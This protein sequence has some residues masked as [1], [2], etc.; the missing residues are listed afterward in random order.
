MSLTCL[1]KP[2]FLDLNYSDLLQNA[3]KNTIKVT[4]DEAKLVE[5]KTRSRL[6]FRMRSGRITLDLRL[7]VS[8]LPHHHS[9]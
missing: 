6:W 8:I 4:P 7:L 3:R 1:Y 5:A 2:E 9:A